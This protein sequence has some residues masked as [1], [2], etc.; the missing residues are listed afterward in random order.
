MRLAEAEKTK[1]KNRTRPEA[2]Y[3]RFAQRIAVARENTERHTEREREE[4]RTERDREESRSAIQVWGATAGRET[5]TGLCSKKLSEG[6][7]LQEEER[8]E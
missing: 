5:E 6:T 7:M 4:S 3:Q 1:E 8:G 2:R